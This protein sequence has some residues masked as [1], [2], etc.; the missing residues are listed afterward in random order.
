MNTEDLIS[1]DDVVK[2]GVL[3][4]IRRATAPILVAVAESELQLERSSVLVAIDQHFFLLSAAHGIREFERT[5][6]R[7][8]TYP[9][10]DENP[11]AVDLTGSRVIA[12]D[13]PV[14]I[15]A[16]S[17]SADC[18]SRMGRAPLSL[19]DI[20]FCSNSNETDSFVVAGYPRALEKKNVRNIP[21]GLSLFTVGYNGP[22]EQ[23]QNFSPNVHL[24]VTWG[25]EF[26]C[27][28]FDN[29]PIP[30]ENTMTRIPNEVG[31]SGGGI[32]RVGYLPPKDCVISKTLGCKLSAIEHRVHRG[33]GYAMGTLAYMG[34]FLIWRE[35]LELRPAIEF[36]MPK[37][38]PAISSI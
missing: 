28:E 25:T 8:Y 22:V 31:I 26:N 38:F 33:M 23:P 34:F 7:I 4:T 29:Q 5:D 19:F 13:E 6:V 16:I 10:N 12:W 14:D 9:A 24:C 17:L 15:C 36:A 32:W 20:D 11:F 18:V 35:Y 30:T 21:R 27:F 2:A 3:N 37:K 1:P